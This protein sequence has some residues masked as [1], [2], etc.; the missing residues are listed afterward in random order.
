MKL[1]GKIAFITGAASGI[2]AA[3]A[4]TFAQE[5]AIIIGTDLSLEKLQS[6]LSDLENVLLLSMDVSD[7]QSVNHT[8]KQ[9]EEKFGKLDILI[10]AAGINA[11]TKDA[12][13][14][15]TQANINAFN[16]AKTGSSFSPDFIESTT[17]EEFKKVLSVNLM[18]TFFCIRAATPLLK[19]N[20]QGS[21]INISSVAALVGPPMP[22]YYPASKAAVLG[23]TKSAA[24][25]LAPYHI[26]VNAV[27][28]GAVDTPFFNEQPTEVTEK[29]IQMQ[30]LARAATPDEIS[31][32]LL[33]LASEDSA[34]YTGQTISPCGGVYM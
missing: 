13:D 19:K 24:R 22:L 28:P 1:K 18:G 10:N 23:M 32:T 15:L 27:A 2:G 21:I 25:E 31:K 29:I 6:S 12:N 3:T 4:R 20:Q 33:F 30:P 5:G 7:S 16:A 11:P 14:R 17:D 8:F 26:R 9:V 34:Y